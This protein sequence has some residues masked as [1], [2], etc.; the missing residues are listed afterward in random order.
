MPSDDPSLRQPSGIFVPLSGIAV[1]PKVRHRCGMARDDLHFRLRIPEDLKAKIAEAAERSRRSMTA[2]IILRLEESFEG[3]PQLTDEEIAIT[4]NRFE[5]IIE[6]EF[7]RDY[8]QQR[9]KLLGNLI[10]KH[11]LVFVPYPKLDKPT[12]PNKSPEPPPKPRRRK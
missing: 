11:K 8:R 5:E 2:E 10:K 3:P 4:A 12:E 1:K 9:D 6:D 7:E